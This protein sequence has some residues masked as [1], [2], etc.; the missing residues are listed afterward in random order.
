V[1]GTPRQRA[2]LSLG[3]G[4]LLMKIAS[5]VINKLGGM[6][7]IFFDRIWPLLERIFPERLNRAFHSVPHRNGQVRQEFRVAARC[8]SRK[9]RRCL[10]QDLEVRARAGQDLFV[11]PRPMLRQLL[12][13]GFLAE[14]TV[15]Q[16]MLRN[17][18]QA[19]ERRG[20][21][22][23]GYAG[24]LGLEAGFTPELALVVSVKPD[25]TLPV[26]LLQSL[27][28]PGVSLADFAPPGGSMRV[29][30][31]LSL[32]NGALTVEQLSV[33]HLV[34][35]LVVGA[36]KQHLEFSGA[37]ESL[38]FEIEDA[39]EDLAFA[40]DSPLTLS[41]PHVQIELNPDRGL[42]VQT[43]QPHGSGLFA[44]LEP[45][46]LLG[47]LRGAASG[48]L[49]PPVVRNESAEKPDG[50]LPEGLRRPWSHEPQQ[51]DLP[52]LLGTLQQ[53]LQLAGH[54]LERQGR[55]H[56]SLAADL[57]LTAILPLDHKFW[58]FFLSSGEPD[59]GYAH[60]R[61]PGYFGNL[62][63]NGAPP[64]EKALASITCGDLKVYALE[65]S[66]FLGLGDKA[67][68][69]YGEEPLLSLDLR[70]EEARGLMR[71]VAVRQ[72]EGGT[73]CLYVRTGTYFCAQAVE[74]KQL[75]EAMQLQV[76]R[77]AA[78]Q[79]RWPAAC[80][81][82]PHGSAPVC[83]GNPDGTWFKPFAPLEPA[84]WFPGTAPPEAG[85][86]RTPVAE[87]EEAARRLGA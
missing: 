83:P 25:L 23:A 18:V 37:I 59:Y 79:Q 74:V 69:P 14:G 4:G 12:H 47:L 87:W 68:E 57:N 52:G 1:P 70:S 58:Q 75:Q 11:Q 30:G 35:P 86:L 29:G 62:E 34:L 7:Q 55:E 67:A 72:L 82:G 17:L 56:V 42:F 22:F 19:Y 85:E 8:R 84:T 65:T 50:Q 53:R 45:E 63:E 32:V 9:G 6:D 21:A 13:S 31:S 20:R 46:S 2:E 71:H 81:P 15:A 26:P 10:G 38:T 33:E 60:L 66:V 73:E 28:G 77:L 64:S 41:L 39:T 5:A 51:L 44:S 3:Y 27:V 48:M 54:T 24:D 76:E 49:V 16:G 61:V 36:E 80:V 78:A 40:K 43:P